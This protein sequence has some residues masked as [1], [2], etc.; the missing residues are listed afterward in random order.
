MLDDSGIEH[1]LGSSALVPIGGRLPY[2]LELQTGRLLDLLMSLSP[3]T[4]INNFREKLRTRLYSRTRPGFY[5]EMNPSLHLAYADQRD[6]HGTQHWWRLFFDDKFRVKIE[7]LIK[8]SA[9][10]VTNQESRNNENFTNANANNLIEWGGMYFRSKTEVKIAETLY[11]NN[12]LFFANVRGQ[13]SPQGSPA[14]VASEQLTGRVEVDFLVFY[15]GKCR[16][17]EVDGQH[18]QEGSQTV[19]DYVRD[20]TLLREGIPTARFTANECYN[21]PADVVTEFLNMFD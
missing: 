4:R 21:R 11:N 17:L 18:H 14:S 12:V 7:S 19:R 8:S 20:R 15:K 2:Y 9:L 16:I 1:Q 13:I 10:T 3:P 5:I 6:G